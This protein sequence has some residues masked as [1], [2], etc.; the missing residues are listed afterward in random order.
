MNGPKWRECMN[1][2]DREMTTD[3]WLALRKEAAAK[4]D[5]K[6]AEVWWDYRQTLDP[7]GVAE[8]LPEELRQIG[9]EYFARTPGTDIWVWFGDLPEEVRSALW[10]KHKRSLAFPA[11]LFEDGTLEPEE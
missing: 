6:N 1:P 11:G 5:P 2:S 4:V 7:Y 10:R 8:S 3:Q 9:R